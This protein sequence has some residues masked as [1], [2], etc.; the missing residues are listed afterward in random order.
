GGWRGH[1]YLPWISEHVPGGRASFSDGPRLAASQVRGRHRITVNHAAARLIGATPGP[2]WRWHTAT[3]PRSGGPPASSPAAPSSP[4]P[5]SARA[6]GS[7]GHALQAHDG[8]STAQA[9][10]GPARPA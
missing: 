6:A 2:G 5:R 7:A 3:T 10:A 4:E 9:T 1:G 8:V